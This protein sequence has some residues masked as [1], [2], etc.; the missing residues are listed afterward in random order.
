MDEFLGLPGGFFNR[1]QVA[2]TLDAET[3]DR[4]AGLCDG[5]DDVIRPVWLDPD[6][7]GSGDVRIFGCADEGIEGQLQVF[8]ELQP[9][10]RVGQRHRAADQAGHAV[11][12][13]IGD[14]VY[15]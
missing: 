12:G 14:V 9:T 10:V 1:L 7:H 2:G 13:S 6:H 4:L 3:G 11:D 5:A 8:A 15:R